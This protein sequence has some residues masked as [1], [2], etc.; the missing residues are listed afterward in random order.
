MLIHIFLLASALCLDTFT[1]GATYGA[2][3]IQISG[4]QVA[5]VNAICSLCLG[6]SLLFGGLLDSFVPERLTKEVGC[7]SLLLL[8]FFKLADSG[9]RQYLNCHH[10]L[11][12]NIHFHFSQLR[13]IIRIYNDP[14]QADVDGNHLLSWQEAIFFALAMSIDSLI[15]GTMAAFLKISVPLTVAVAFLVGELSTHLGLA[16]GKRIS[17]RCPRDLSWVGGILF[18]LL[19]VCRL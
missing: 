13:F 6:V 5:V 9:I 8:G 10:T 17:R 1:A 2:S 19:A 7:I 16:L 15:A 18:L 11:D 14:E 3:G 4:R 12:K